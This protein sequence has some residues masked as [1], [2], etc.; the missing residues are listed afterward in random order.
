MLGTPPKG[1]KDKAT[2]RHAEAL[3]PPTPRAPREAFSLTRLRAAPT[4]TPMTATN[5]APDPL[6]RAS[7]APP[8][9]LAA[10]AAAYALALTNHWAVKPDSAMYLALGRALAEGRGMEF[11]GL[12][13]W[14]V[15]PLL[16]L[17]LAACRLLAG[18]AFWL[19]NLLLSLFGFGTVLLA[20]LAV[21]RLAADRPTPEHAS[22]ALAALLIV[23][24]SARLFIDSTRILTDVPFLFWITLVLYALLRARDG[25][26]AWSLA[27][28]AAILLAMATRLVGLALFP[29]FLLA[30]LL[31]VRAPGYRRRLAATLGGLAAIAAL[32]LAWAVWVRGWSGPGS[33]D[34]LRHTLVDHLNFAAAWRWP[35]IPTGLARLPGALCES[36]SGQEL[37]LFNLLPAALIAVGLAVAARSRQWT[38]ACPVV[39]YVA[40]LVWLGGAAVAPRYLL[41][42]MPALVYLLLVGTVR[43]AAW[44]KLRPRAALTVVAAFSIAVSAPKAVREIY[45]MRLGRPVESTRDGQWADY[46]N[47]GARLAEHGQPGDLVF[48]PDAAVIHY[49]SRLRAVSALYHP[50]T[51]IYYAL[52][53]SSP[54][55][56]IATVAAD[57]GCRFVVVPRLD[58]DWNQA[59][60]DALQRDAGFAPATDSFGRLVL[61]ERPAPHDGA[62]RNAE[63]G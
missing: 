45:R 16:P 13:T 41:A 56:M 9:V 15:P 31:D 38:V 54:P 27:A 47:V 2:T 44:L 58:P 5:P 63:P 34:Y 59:V 18:N 28:L 23:G 22:L 4:I 53:P 37:K 8:I 48:T 57:A 46:R 26:W 19:P 39:L 60:S 52:Q 50:T 6:A 11:N 1:V 55:A 24:S 32:F 7:R 43:A 40:F 61:F 49:F 30:V 14:G 17:L 20:Y 51:D 62:G 29:G 33:P 12:Q 3:N 21:R 25:H 36:I 35:R 10:V 42:V